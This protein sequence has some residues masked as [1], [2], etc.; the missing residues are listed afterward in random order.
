MQKSRTESK[1]I[2]EEKERFSQKEKI[3]SNIEVSVVLMYEWNHLCRN[4][5]YAEFTMWAITVSLLHWLQQSSIQLV[6]FTFLQG[7]TKKVTLQFALLF[8][9]GEQLWTTIKTVFSMEIFAQD[10]EVLCQLQ[11]HFS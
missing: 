1:I 9:E 8:F 3:Q 11:I 5:D 10:H 6:H 4:V 7:M 2:S